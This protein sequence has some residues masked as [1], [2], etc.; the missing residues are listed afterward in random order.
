MTPGSLTAS[1]D[2]ITDKTQGCKYFPLEES[3]RY[4]CCSGNTNGI[5]NNNNVVNI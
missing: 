5:S 2:R 4:D 3:M 1:L